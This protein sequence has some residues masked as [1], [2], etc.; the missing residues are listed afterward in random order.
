MRMNRSWR[1]TA[2]I[3]AAT[4][5]AA[6]IGIPTDVLDTDLF[7]R[8]TPVRWWEYPVLA[9][10]AALTGLW[11]AIPRGT[12]TLRGGGGVVGATTATVFAVGCPI[13]N[14]LVVGL[15]GVSGALGIWAPIQPVLAALSLAALA[16]AIVLRWRRRDRT[17]DTCAPDGTAATD[18]DSPARTNTIYTATRP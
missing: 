14:K 15:L 16:A 11:V 9:L 18:G 17:T 5:S 13:C 7:T 6:V 8:M 10:A 12:D 1:W 3:G 2:G 4:L